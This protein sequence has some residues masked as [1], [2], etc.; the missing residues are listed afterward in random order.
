VIFGSLVLFKMKDC[1]VFI[2]GAY[3]SLVSRFL[4]GG[5]HMKF[6]IRKF[7]E[8][9]AQKEDLICKQIFYYNCPPF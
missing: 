3:L 4:G 6:D 7:A 5:K 9:L 8:S 2:D 1:I